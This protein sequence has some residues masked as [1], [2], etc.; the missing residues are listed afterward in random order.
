[1][2]GI[3]GIMARYHKLFFAQLKYDPCVYITLN[4]FTV[5]KKYLYIKNFGIKRQIIYPAW[6]Q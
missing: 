1:M 5:L 2:L 6:K 3:P 4:G